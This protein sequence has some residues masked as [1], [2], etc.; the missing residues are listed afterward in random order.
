MSTHPRSRDTAH[1]KTTYIGLFYARSPC[2]SGCRLPY[3]PCHVLLRKGE[4]AGK[5]YFLVLP[6]AYIM[7]EKTTW[8]LYLSHHNHR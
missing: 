1:A 8:N 7:R 3:S 4:N 6:Y 5:L 2:L